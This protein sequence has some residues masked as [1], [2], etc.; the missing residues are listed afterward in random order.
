MTSSPK[1]LSNMSRPPEPLP[2]HSSEAE[3]S[4]IGSLLMDPERII[5]IAP[6]LKAEDFHDITYRNIYRAIT[7]L[8]EERKPVDFVTVAEELKSDEN[9]QALGGSGFLAGLSADV[10]TSSHAP[11]YAAIVR[12]RSL[13]RQLQDAGL[14]ISGLGTDERLPALDALERAEQELLA[15]TRHV[16]ESRPMHIADVASES[17]SRYADLQAAEDKTSLFGLTTGFPVLDHMLTGFRPEASRSLPRGLRPANQRFALDIARHAAAK[18]AKN[19]AVFSLEMTKQ[20]IMDRVI[21]GHS[22]ASKPGSSRRAN[23][24]MQTSVAWEPSSMS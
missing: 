13:H 12:D 16:A 5:D 9:I 7:R 15:I 23:C 10:P 8:Y 14:R 22:W 18:Q 17:F 6:H 24:P 2:P 21:A 4:T 1:E 20:E 19:V 11:H 3:R